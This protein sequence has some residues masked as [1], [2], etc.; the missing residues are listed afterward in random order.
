M[1]KTFILI[2]CLACILSSCNKSLDLIPT[3]QVS[4][5][6]YLTDELHLLTYAN[7]LYPNIITF[8][9]GPELLRDRD[10]D[11]QAY[12]SYSNKYVP[13]QQKVAQTNGD[14]KFKNIYD[15][16]YFIETVMPR[17]EAGTITGDANNVKHY[18]GEVFFLRAL[19]YFNK[20]QKFGDFPIITE[21]LPDEQDALVEA[22]KRSPRNEVARFII[23]DLDK[24]IELMA[25]NPD[26][27][28]TRISKEAALLLKSRVALYEGTFLKYFKG[29]AFVPKGEGWPGDSKEYS[30]S[31]TY[32]GGNIDSEINWFLEQAIAASKEV[33]E[34]VG[35]TNNTYAIQQSSSDPANPYYDLFAST[36]LSSFPEAIL[37]R[38]YS[39]SLSVT[40][41]MGVFGQ[42][43][44]CGVGVTRGMVESY[45]MS[46][47]LPI[48]AEGSGYKGDDYISTVKEGRDNRLVIFLKE[49]G[50]KNYIYANPIG[51]QAVEIEPLPMIFGSDYSVVYPTGYAVRKGNP[52]DQEQD[53]TQKAYT[54]IVVFRSA[55]AML[56]YIEA[57]Y[58][59]YGNLDSNADKYWKQIRNRAGVDPDYEK[60][61]SATQM[62]KEALNSWGAYSSGKII[63]PTLYNI[64][65]ERACE[66][67]G[68]GLRAMD[69]QRWRSYDQMKTVPYH[70]EGFKVWGPMEEWYGSQLVYG[71]D[72]DKATVSSP[73]LSL[74]IRPY[75]RVRTSLVLEGYKW[76]MA[77][78]LTPI[79]VQE[80]ILTSDG[81]NLASSPIY[82]N[83]YWSLNVGD[84]AIE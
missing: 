69:L 53:V 7:N 9:V 44:N 26:S 21:V 47:G 17:Y 61:I 20:Y 56:N 51:N 19:E 4:P 68:E 10:T 35:L 81:G 24:A 27:R 2:I 16:N 58:E 29:T 36:D 22:S 74:Y 45:L 73:E 37:W 71:L 8:T 79:P 25:T 23:S 67:L 52:L 75:E 65:R 38:E 3:S 12:M 32:P 60:T 55:E 11:V 62:D 18:I 30:K 59:R 77:H 76:A 41:D 1:K 40:H 14:W 39:R 43:G 63:D 50:Q 34:T 46:N 48:Y 49:P 54:G 64:R 33:A 57:Y 82:Q 70:I 42:R 5:E 72:N 15:C 13:G 78:Y 31:Y 80:V 6:K 84:G 28:G 66:F 83:P